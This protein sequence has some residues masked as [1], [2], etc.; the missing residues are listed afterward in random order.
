MSA[1]VSKLQQASEALAK[2]ALEAGQVNLSNQ[3]SEMLSEMKHIHSALSKLNLKTEETAP[4]ETAHNKAVEAKLG[5]LQN[6]NEAVLEAMKTANKLAKQS[7][8]V[9]A[10]AALCQQSSHNIYSYH[11]DE[12]CDMIIIFM[13]GKG[14][15]LC[16]EQDRKSVV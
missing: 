6:S 1:Q 15:F 4:K 16:T 10:H 8:L 14:G 11:N 9:N 7:L 5:A 2:A 13:E 12:A 3:Q